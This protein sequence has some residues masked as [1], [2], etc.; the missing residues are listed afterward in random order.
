MSLQGSKTTSSYIE[1]NAIQSLIQRL[2]RDGDGKFALLIAV[3]AFTGLRIGDILTLKWNNL[4]G[5]DNLRVVEQKTRKERK[6]TINPQLLEIVT[7]IYKSQH[8]IN[9]DSLIF[10]NRWGKRAISRQFVN[11]KLKEIAAKYK[12]T[13]DPTSIKSHSLRKSFGRR[14][15]ENNDNSELALILLSD[16]LNHSSIKTTKLYLGIR[17]KEIQDVY[18]NL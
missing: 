16:I 13:K 2:E 18:A 1:W 11:H 17:E 12:I 10:L 9:R 3:G 4:L 15:F 14:V 8:G 7:R 5:Q 6:I